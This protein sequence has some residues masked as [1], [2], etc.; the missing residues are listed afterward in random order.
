MVQ[1]SRVAMLT[2]TSSKTNADGASIPRQQ[3]Q[4]FK[5]VKAAKGKV[6]QIL[7]NTGVAGSVPF[8][9]RPG[10]QQFLAKCA[11]DRIS[12]IVVADEKR[13]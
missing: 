6:T 8:M 4:I 5:S 2:R 7:V 3:E 10:M 12:K 1:H 9:L 11:L 13:L